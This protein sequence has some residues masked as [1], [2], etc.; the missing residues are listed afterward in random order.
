MLEVEG[1]TRLGLGP[2]DLTVP[3]GCLAVLMG[4]SG[5]GKS[6]LLRALADLDPATGRVRLDG[7]DR[8]ALPAPLWR[9][10]VV[11]LAAEAGWWA[12][13][14]GAHFADRAAA[15]ALLPALGLPAEALDWDIARASTGER[16]RLA[17]ARCLTLPRAPETPRLYLL[18][19]PTSALDAESVARAEP[20][21]RALPDARTAVLMVS[22]DAAQAARLGDRR[23]VLTEGRVTVVSGPDPG[24]G[25]G[26]GPGTAS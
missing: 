14:V 24:P 21:L 23:L 8:A 3:A 4:A 9:R 25:P 7:V 6:L 5:A 20:I 2:V 1:L 12:D 17:L 22:H 15:R 26:P 11:Y 18:D 16:Q 13:R 10:R 19:E